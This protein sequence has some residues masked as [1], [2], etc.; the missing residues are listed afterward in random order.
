MNSGEF[1]HHLMWKIKNINLESDGA[2]VENQEIL[3]HMAGRKV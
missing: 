1:R 3:R 2:L